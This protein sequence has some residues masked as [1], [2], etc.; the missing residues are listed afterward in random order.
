MSNIVCSPIKGR[1][2]PITEVNDEMFAKKM[3]GDGVAIIPQEKEIYSPIDGEV[4]MVYKTE[5]AIALKGK[6]EILI[7]IGI[8]TVELEGKPFTTKVKIGDKV[9]KGDLL[10]IVDWNY[11]IK[12]GKDIVVPIIVTDNKA[13]T[14]IKDNG[15]ILVGEPIYKIE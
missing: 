2:I 5:H 15:D 1:L 3:I 13:I 6:N 9:K 14:I 12:E 4:I 8:D 7:H 10:T 11:I